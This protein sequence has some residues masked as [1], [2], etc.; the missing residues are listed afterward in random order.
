MFQGIA[1]GKDELYLFFGEDNG[2]SI[3]GKFLKDNQERNI[4]KGIL[5]PFMKG[6]DVHRYAN[7]PKGLFIL[8]PYSIDDKGRAMILKEEEIEKQF[9]NAYQWL[10]ETEIEH[11]KKDGRSTNDEFWYRYARK[12]GID[13]VEQHKLSSMEICSSYPNVIINDKN[14]YHPTTVYSWV[15]NQEATESYEYFLAIANSKLLW[16]F[17]KNTGDTLQGDARRFKTNYLNPFP[18]P[19]IVDLVTEQRISEK[20]KEV[21]FLKKSDPNADTSALESEIDQMV[22]ALYGLTEEEIEIVEN[23]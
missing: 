10:K 23:C 22:Y 9:P 4:E 6:K 1:T 11:R 20:V 7:P 5:K 19:G 18:I 14:F 16:W 3:K 12:Q 8:F 2:A 21:L 15:K 13:N 17:L